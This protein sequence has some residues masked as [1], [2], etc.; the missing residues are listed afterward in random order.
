MAGVRV[1]P[2]N[3]STA[4]GSNN[5]SVLL[6]S[7]RVP[8]SSEPLDPLFIPGSSPSSFLGILSSFS[9]FGFLK[10]PCFATLIENHN[11]RK[12]TKVV[13]WLLTNQCS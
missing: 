2:S 13:N 6:Q 11:K 1:Y 8:S 4:G 3:T 7:Q 12:M 5:L 10:N 9:R